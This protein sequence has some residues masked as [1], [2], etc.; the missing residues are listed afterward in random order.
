MTLIRVPALIALAATVLPACV[1]RVLAVVWIVTEPPL[2]VLA[3]IVL[4][5]TLDTV[6]ASHWPC[7]PGVA[8]GIWALLMFPCATVS[9]WALSAPPCATASVWALF[10][11][12]DA[13][14]AAWMVPVVDPR[15]A[16]TP[17]ASMKAKARPPIRSH[18]RPR[19]CGA[20]G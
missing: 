11:L 12:P 13:T 3:T 8:V 18:L 4:P 17:R 14:V 2:D 16:P 20:G 5:F 1:Y 6:S 15:R 10:E 19:R 9:V 7:A